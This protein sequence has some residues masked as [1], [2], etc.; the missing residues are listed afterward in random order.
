MPTYRPTPITRT[1]GLLLLTVPLYSLERARPQPARLSPSP[2]VAPP[3]PATP[4]AAARH[5]ARRCWA[6]AAQAVNNE[7]EVLEAWDPDGTENLNQEQWRRQLMA[8]D[9]GGEL[10][11]ALKWGR[12][13]AALARTSNDKYAAAQLLARVECDA[14]HHDEELA[15]ARKLMALRPRSLDS[16][17]LLQRAAMCNRLEALESQTAAELRKLGC[18]W[19]TGNEESCREQ[20][21]AKPRFGAGSGGGEGWGWHEG[22]PLTSARSGS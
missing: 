8:A 6:R 22:T 19:T 13:A 12:H 21:R 5:V 10:Q 20:G 9:H 4:S 7:R 14:G 1:L 15:Q 2:L 3:P 18:V 17:M 16:L 11:R